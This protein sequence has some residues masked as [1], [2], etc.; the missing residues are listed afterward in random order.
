MY[1]VSEIKTCPNTRSY[2]TGAGA[3]AH[4][5][6]EEEE[7]YPYHSPDDSYSVSKEMLQ[8]KNLVS[9]ASSKRLEG[10]YICNGNTVSKVQ[11]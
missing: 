4:V 7:R 9:K 1:L 11:K 8:S 6:R 10:S 3:L 5:S 2:G